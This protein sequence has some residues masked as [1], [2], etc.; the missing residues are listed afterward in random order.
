M[1]TVKT[2]EYI[3]QALE[4]LG[5]KRTTGQAWQRAVSGGRLTVTLLDYGNPLFRGTWTDGRLTDTVFFELGLSEVADRD[6]RDNLLTWA[7][8]YVGGNRMT[9]NGT[10][11]YAGAAA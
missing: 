6:A 1:N 7:T 11:G 2:I 3:E 10:I 9:E 5:F 8:W 4:T